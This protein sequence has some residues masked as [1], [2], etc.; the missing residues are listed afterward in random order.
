MLGKQNDEEPWNYSQE[1]CLDNLFPSLEN[2]TYPTD[3]SD[4]YG[5]VKQE[6]Y[7]C[8][9]VF[10]PTLLT[11]HLCFSQTPSPALLPAWPPH[12]N[13]LSLVT[14]SPGGSQSL[15]LPNSCASY[16]VHLA[17]RAAWLDDPTARHKKKKS[18]ALTY[19]NWK[20]WFTSVSSYE[21]N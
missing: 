2:I 5:S 4:I 10:A 19:T 15:C 1:G 11:V 13:S 20:H 17:D 9:S 18:K 21:L 14:G 3:K 6:Y 8:L 12:N 16:C 7:L